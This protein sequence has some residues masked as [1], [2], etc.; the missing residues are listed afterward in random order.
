MTAH[1]ITSEITKI[2]I[3]N[4]SILLDNTHTPNHETIEEI[5]AFNTKQISDF[6]KA[7]Y[8]SVISA[9]E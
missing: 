3:E 2:A 7:I 4:K 1:E 6:Y 8:N 9:D 5:N